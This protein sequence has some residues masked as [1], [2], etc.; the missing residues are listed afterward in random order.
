LFSVYEEVP[1]K[2]EEWTSNGI[3]V[4]IYSSGS[5]LAQK[6]L[7]GYTLYGDLTKVTLLR[8]WFLILT[9]DIIIQYISHYFDTK[10]GAKQEPASYEAISASVNLP[11]NDILFLTDIVR[12]NI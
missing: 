2:F 12:G 3:A 6:L 5:V 9:F 8:M 10:V 4:A 7:F 11:A 1:A